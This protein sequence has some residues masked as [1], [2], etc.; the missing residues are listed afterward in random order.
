MATRTD[1]TTFFFTHVTISHQQ[2]RI[3]SNSY[4]QSILSN[5]LQHHCQLLY[6]NEYAVYIYIYIYIYFVL[7]LLI[8]VILL[9]TDLRLIHPFTPY[10]PSYIYYFIV[11]ILMLFG[12]K[13]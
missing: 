7:L 13:W 2:N 5:I 10:T 3:V 12:I 11:C 6:S 1:S 4:S 8:V 9:G